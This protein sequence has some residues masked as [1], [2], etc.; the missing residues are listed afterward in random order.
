MSLTYGGKLGIGRTDPRE[1]FEVVG[2][3]TVTGNSFVG[4][5][6]RVGGNLTIDGTLSADSGGSTNFNVGIITGSKLISLSSITSGDDVFVNRNLQTNN[7]YERNVNNGIVFHNITK[8]NVDS[9]H[10]GNVGINSGYNLNVYDSGTIVVSSNSDGSGVGTASTITTQFVASKNFY[11]SLFDGRH[12][13]TN[14]AQI[15]IITVTNLKVTGVSSITFDDLTASSLTIN[16][17]RGVFIGQALYDP[18]FANFVGIGTTQKIGGVTFYSFGTVL[19]PQ[20]I[21]GISTYRSINNQETPTNFGVG[22]YGRALYAEDSEVKLF[23]TSTVS[24]GN[25]ENS[26]T[27]PNTIIDTYGKSIIGIGTITPNAIID[28]SNAGRGLTSTITDLGKTGLQMRFM[29]PPSITTTERVGLATVEG[30]FIFNTTTKK[31]QGYNGTAW[32]DFY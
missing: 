7:I 22:L 5:N 1:T 12:L 19:A 24:I 11:G 26:G 15:G 23:G 13:N 32:F 4:G 21:A 30:A 25:S 16:S 9:K 3:S 17:N 27:S 28:F 6:L 20:F 18:D 14:S 29:L 8:F 10:Y 2:T 31:H